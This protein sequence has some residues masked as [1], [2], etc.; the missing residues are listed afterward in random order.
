MH[1]GWFVVHCIKINPTNGIHQPTNGI[2]GG[3]TIWDAVI[4]V[5]V[6]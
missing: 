2:D 1:G 6:P 5:N 3:M 4:T